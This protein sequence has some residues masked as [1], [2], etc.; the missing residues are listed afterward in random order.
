MA[1]LNQQNNHETE[2]KL[3]VASA[4]EALRRLAA[5]GFVESK[6][7]GFEANE[8]F[9]TVDGLLRGRGEVLRVREFGGQAVLTFKGQAVLGGRHKSREELETQVGEA[10]VLRLMLERLGYRPTYRYEKYRTEFARAGEAGQ[11]VATVDETP[12]GVFMELEGEG[13]WIDRMAEAMGFAESEYVTD[14][15]AAL[16]RQYCQEHCA[17]AGKGMVF[18]D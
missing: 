16:Y 9:D 15:Y 3:R 18:E 7:R 13:A 17:E 6:A 11:G 5:A 8:L 1:G 12:I 2:I 4:G 10:A 14:S